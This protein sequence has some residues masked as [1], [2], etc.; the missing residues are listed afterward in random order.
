[1]STENTTEQRYRDLVADE[2]RQPGDEYL[3]HNG[4]WVPL[5]CGGGDAYKPPIDGVAYVHLPHRR[6]IPPPDAASDTPETDAESQW[7]TVESVTDALVR[8]ADFARKLE[9]ER[10]LHQKRITELETAL[11]IKTEQIETIRQAIR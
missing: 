8:F 11:Q 6:P 2:I 3:A 4:K 5:T 10:N 7:R 1:M 9:R